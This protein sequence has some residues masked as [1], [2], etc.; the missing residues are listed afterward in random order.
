MAKYNGQDLGI[1]FHKFP[2]QYIPDYAWDR[3][4]KARASH[5]LKTKPRQPEQKTLF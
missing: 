2:A 5:G 4:V 1:P 3:Y